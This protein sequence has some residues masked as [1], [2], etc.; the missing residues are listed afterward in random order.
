[1]EQYWTCIKR[2]LWCL[3]A[4]HAIFAGCWDMTV[5]CNCASVYTVFSWC[6]DIDGGLDCDA[7]CICRWVL[8]F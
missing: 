5:A 7:V 1:M 8:M 6:E 2:I 4:G 3:L